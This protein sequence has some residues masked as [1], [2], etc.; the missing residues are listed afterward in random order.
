MPGR[1]LGSASRERLLGYWRGGGDELG[2]PGDRCT[3]ATGPQRPGIRSDIAEQVIGH[4]G[5]TR[6]GAGTHYLHH[7]YVDER[8]NALE[9]WS[10][11]LVGVID[12]TN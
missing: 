4:I 5:S 7:G 2:G 3:A 12:L 6:S 8:M 10:H 1:R 11:H 9:T